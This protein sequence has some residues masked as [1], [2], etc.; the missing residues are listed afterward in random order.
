MSTRPVRT[1][2]PPN[3]LTTRASEA[4][5]ITQVET[6]VRKRASKANKNTKPIKKIDIIK[7]IRNKKFMKLASLYQIMEETQIQRNIE[8]GSYRGELLSLI[9]KQQEVIEKSTIKIE[10]KKFTFKSDDIK[11]DFLVLMWLDMSHDATV[12]KG[13]RAGITT[14]I[15]IYHTFRE[16]LDLKISNILVPD[17]PKIKITEFISKLRGVGAID[18]NTNNSNIDITTSPGFEGKIK[19]SFE[20]LFDLKDILKGTSSE[21][22]GKYLKNK[23]N[24][25]YIS[26]DQESDKQSPISLLII[27]SKYENIRSNG[28]KK[29]LYGIKSLVTLA[30]IIDPGALKGKKGSLL[31]DVSQLFER[32]PRVFSTFVDITKFNLDGK[33]IEIIP[34]STTY[35]KYDLK[36]GTKTVEGGK[37]KGKAQEKNDELL[38]I[39]KFCGDFLQI[40]SVA[41]AQKTINCTVGTGDA[42]MATMHLFIQKYVLGEPN[43]RILFDKSYTTGR[44]NI[45][46]CGFSEQFIPNYVKN[47]AISP[48]NK[49]GVTRPARGRTN[50]KGVNQPAKRKRTPNA[51]QNVPMPKRAR[52]LTP[53]SRGAPSRNNTAGRQSQQVNRPRSNTGSITRSSSVRPPK[54]ISVKGK[55][56][57]VSN[58]SSGITKRR[59]HNSVTQ[60]RSGNGK[61]ESIT[62]TVSAKP[63][64]IMKTASAKTESITRTV[65]ARQGSATSNSA[66]SNQTRG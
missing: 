65:S 41:A 38:K 64:S 10:P 8:G 30:N 66:R 33:I 11:L 28:T 20:N 22:I 44:S 48:T 12:I 51:Q 47:K 45:I 1:R 56:L 55:N 36:I 57:I 50:N 31:R 37:T 62:R 25:I 14:K 60:N 9:N 58:A 6:K 59:R 34:S 52:Q 54:Q 61:V 7:N 17:T 15:P 2:K 4:N 49:T 39:S 42:M 18:Y 3:R 29:S 13:W 26:V 23:N 63:E 21:S 43:P 24:P 19:T 40:L 53:V 27:K 46:I 16:F 32:P 5:K 35:G